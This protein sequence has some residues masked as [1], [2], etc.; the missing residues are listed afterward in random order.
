MAER[1]CSVEG[2]ERPRYALG[3]CQGHYV[4]QRRGVS[5]NDTPLRSP[6]LRATCR[7]DGCDSPVRTRDMCAFHYRRLRGGVALDAP[8]RHQSGQPCPIEG[9]LRSTARGGLCDVH[10]GRRRNG[11]PM[12]APIRSKA[13]SGSGFLAGG[14]HISTIDGRQVPTHRVVMEQVLGRPL[15][16]HENVHHVNGIRDDNRLENLELWV[17]PQPSGRRAS[18]LAEWV[19]DR[20]PELV[21]AALAGR[22][23]LR[24]TT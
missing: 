1:T 20:Y 10:Y 6:V 19:V 9:C 13:P 8:V 22:R 24:L 4:R 3:L 21:E 15:A 23:Q 5:L 17:R 16:D 11:Q 14:Y 7:Q 12:T 18:D 2:C